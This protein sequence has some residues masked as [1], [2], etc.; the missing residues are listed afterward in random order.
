M[1][2]VHYR[3]HHPM[4]L[5]KVIDNARHSVTIVAPQVDDAL[6]E[7]LFAIA[8]PLDVN[9][10]TSRSSVEDGGRRLRNHIK[11]L[12]D[13]NHRVDVRVTDESFPAFT[14][15]DGEHLYCYSSTSERMA[16][17]KPE[18]LMET[19]QSLWSSGTP[20]VSRH[21]RTSSESVPGAQ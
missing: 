7:P 10:L 20:L 11:Q 8:R 19:A 14:I 15:V 5:P 18:S 4:A 12:Q 13:I 21:L 9:L 16:S 3:R 1:K 17:K 2:S 6:L